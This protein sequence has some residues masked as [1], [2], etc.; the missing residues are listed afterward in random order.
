MQ[1]GIPIFFVVNYRMSYKDTSIELKERRGQCLFKIEDDV[2]YITRGDNAALDIT[3]Y[4]DESQS[5]EYELQ[6]GDKF[7]FSVRKIASAGSELVFAVETTTNRIVLSHEDTADKEVGKYS[8]DVQLNTANGD[9]YTIWPQFSVTKP[10]KEFNY[11]NFCIMP[12][13]TMV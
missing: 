10:S 11:K 12:E 5:E 9:R 4:I 8:A 7:I 2:I 3:A 1:K 13:V 6:E